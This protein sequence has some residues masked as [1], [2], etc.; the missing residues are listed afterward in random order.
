MAGESVAGGSDVAAP[1]RLD[2]P[3]LARRPA[4]S[5]FVRLILDA[6]PDW[7][8]LPGQFINALCESDPQAVMAAEGRVLDDAEGGE[9]PQTTGLEL[10]RR[11]PLVRRPLSISRVFRDAGRV[12]LDILVRAVGAGTQWLASRPVGATLNLVGP[13][14]NHF[15]LPEGDRLCLLVGGG[16]GVAPIFG[17]ADY[18]VALGRRSVA[19]LGAANIHKMPTTFRELPEPTHHAIALTDDVSEFAE[20]ETPTVV[21]TDDGS[22]GYFGTASAALEEYLRTLWKG[23][24]V[25]LYGCGPMPMI[26]A[27]GE[28]ARRRDLPCQVSLEGFM[29]CGIGVCLSC[30]TKRHEPASEKGWTF[31]LTCRDGPVVDARD[32]VWE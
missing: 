6:P 18:L 22:A 27:L 13:L 7:D 2:L 1:R 21:A 28:T 24:P 25:A 29:G 11:W 30:A 17:L 5:S 31:R 32:L 14:G 12:R 9:W 10:A 19:F 8:S 15:T 4:G 20:S 23:E 16:C 26:R 3:L